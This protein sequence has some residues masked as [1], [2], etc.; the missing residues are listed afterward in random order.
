MRPTLF[1]IPL[2]SLLLAACATSPDGTGSRFTGSSGPVEWEVV[3]MGRITRSDGMRLRWSYTTVLREKA[4]SAVQFETL[5]YGILTHNVGT[6]GFRRSEF[7]RRLEARSEI[8]LNTVD[9]WGWTASGA[10]RQFGATAELGTMIVERRYIGKNAQGQAIVVPI[11]LELHRGSGR[12]S[13]QPASSD[14]PLPPTRLL[15]TAD[16]GSLAGQWEGYYQRDGFHVPMAATVRDDG[17]VELAENDPPTLRFRAKLSIR[18]GRVAYTG[19][20][21]GEFALHQDGIRRVL[22]GAV[23]LPA[24]GTASSVTLPV[25]FESTPSTAAAS[26]PPTAPTAP[27]PL[28]AVTAMPSGAAPSGA[29]PLTGTYRGTVSGD[30]QGRPYSAQITLTLAQQGDQVTGTW[31][32]AGG[33]SG[34]VSG[35]LLSPTRAELRIEQLHPC[36]AQFTGAATIGEGGSS[37]GGSYSGP[38]CAGQVSTSFTVV[39]Q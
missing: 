21:T 26:T 10:S 9:S 38:G 12:P 19:Q 25:R 14:P 28:G 23:T 31:L 37:L 5:E 29:N 7:S 15:Q 8:R 6:G 1:V 17:S 20:Q 33:G 16:L 11:R 13:R 39:R 2:V 18:E 36:P 27:N 22:V 32:T 30:Q 24:T 3:D 35:R 34:T 4:G